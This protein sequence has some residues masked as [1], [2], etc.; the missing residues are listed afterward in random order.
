MFEASKKEE[1]GYGIYNNVVT[2]S[3]LENWFNGN[4]DERIDSSS[5]KT[6][7][8]VHCVGSRD[9]KAGNGQCSKVCCITAIKQAIELKEMYPDAQIY[10]FY[11]D[12]RLFGKKFEDFYTKAQR[13]HGIHFIRGRVSEVSENIDG[14]LIVKAEDTLLGK[15]L[16]VTL[17]LLVLMSG[18]T[19][20]PDS[21]R[22]ASMISLPTD[23]D[24]FLKS[25][26]N[27]THITSSPKKG[28]FYAGACTGPKTVPETLAEA[29]SA[30]LD[31][32]FKIQES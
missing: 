31:I 12:L 23:S 20:N 5:M 13:D 11:M 29:R 25:E 18:M 16:K 10:C 15:P 9:E 24:R 8:F 7:G 2:N 28:V 3:D 17:D 22:I 32:H 19:C 1:Y 26:D 30:A 27:I 14:K 4:R 6:I 21:S